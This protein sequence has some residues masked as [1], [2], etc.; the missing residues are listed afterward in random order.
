MGD[1]ARVDLSK[2]VLV[3]GRAD[4]LAYVMGQGPGAVLSAAGRN[5]TTAA[6]AEGDF[7]WKAVAT[8]SQRCLE[9]VVAGGSMT[10]LADLAA[11][12]AARSDAAPTEPPADMGGRGTCRC[13]PGRQWEALRGVA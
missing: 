4:E 3:N 11:G 1:C 13:R 6:V 10:P 2:A 7:A 8:E 5:G 12:G 9:V